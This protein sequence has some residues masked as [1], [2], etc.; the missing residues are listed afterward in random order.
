MSRCRAIGVVWVVALA[1][2][3]PAF[4]QASAPGPAKALFAR[5][6]ADTRTLVRALSPI[7]P[8]VQSLS[9]S[10]PKTTAGSPTDPQVSTDLDA[11]VAGLSE[12]GRNSR[13]LV[14]SLRQ[15]VR[16][17]RVGDRP[18]VRQQLQTAEALAAQIV[19]ATVTIPAVLA[20]I[21]ARLGVTP[22][23]QYAVAQ[24]AMQR[25]GL[26]V[27]TAAAAAA[28]IQVALATLPR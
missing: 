23:D 19:S 27:Q 15:A 11:L 6:V 8:S 12:I 13:S 14:K 2:A 26:A 21:Q 1:A 5:V 17:A 28:D 20:D 24:Q 4:S 9:D 18:G 7:R 25:I 10:L 16:A 22:P 3:A